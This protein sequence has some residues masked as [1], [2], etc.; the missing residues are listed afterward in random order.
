LLLPFAAC[1]CSSRVFFC[2][3]PVT[4]AARSAEAHVHDMIAAAEAAAGVVSAGAVTCLHLASGL[5]YTGGAAYE[6]PCHTPPSLSAA[7]PGSAAGTL[8]ADGVTSFVTYQRLD[9]ATMS[10]I[11]TLTALGGIF[12]WLNLLEVASPALWPRLHC[13][14]PLFLIFTGLYGYVTD[15]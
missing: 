11:D 14:D 13:A 15:M 2:P 3:L 10:A 8:A 7:G 5:G 6:G 4:P 9:D 12:L 1:N